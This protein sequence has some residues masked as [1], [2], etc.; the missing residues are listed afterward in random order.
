MTHLNNAYNG[1]FDA[2]LLSTSVGETDLTGRLT[3]VNDKFCEMTNYRKDE[4]IGKHISMLGA[5]IQSSGFFLN[6]LKIIFHGD[7]WFGEICMTTKEGNFFWVDTTIAPIKYPNSN[8]LLKYVI[9]CNNLSTTKHLN[10][11]NLTRNFE[12]QFKSIDG[13]AQLQQQL[14]EVEKLQTIGKLTSGIAHDFNNVLGCIVGYNKM[15]EELT[16]KVSDNAVKEEFTENLLAVKRASERATELIGKIS[17]YLRVETQKEIKPI[18]APLVVKE[19]VNM[20]R[21]VIPSTIKISTSFSE[22]PDIT[23]NTIDLHQVLT[24]LIVNA[25]D[26]IEGHGNIRID[27][28]VVEKTAQCTICM[29]DIDSK[30]VQ[31]SISDDG[32]GIEEGKIKKVFDAFFT[33]KEIGKGTGLGLLAVSNV[34]HNVG[35]HVAVESQLGVGTTFKLLFPIFDHLEF[36]ETVSAYLSVNQENTELTEKIYRVLVIDDDKD[37]AKLIEKWL[38]SN[39]QKCEFFTNSEEALL[40]FLK[41]PQTFDV[42]ISDN[43]MPNLTGVELAKVVLAMRKTMPIIIVSGTLDDISKDDPL[44]SLENVHFLRKPINFNE[45]AKILVALD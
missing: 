7:A 38:I 37:S 24:N 33:T 23:I 22:I 28:R 10:E 8:E 32:C 30:F 5:K 29:E 11:D 36:N 34:V 18:N 6:I 2:L 15:C 44:F 21:G 14:L 1:L 26:A 35:G 19:V 31:I 25:R 43:V 12:H 9:L 40:Y 16:H 27:A 39:G 20:L 42:I 45:I 4:L 17:Q 3:F 41:K 13:R